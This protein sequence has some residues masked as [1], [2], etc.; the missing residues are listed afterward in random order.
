MNSS[1]INFN[2]K[3]HTILNGI[4]Y[5]NGIK[6]DKVLIQVHGMTS[7]CFKIRNQIIAKTIAS[8][9]IDTIDFN[10]RGSEIIKYISDGKTK[11][12]A[13]TAYENIE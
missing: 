10:N 13:G 4:I 3:D 1:I 7:N 2:A 8:I 11:K 9:K 6:T 12:L 5:T